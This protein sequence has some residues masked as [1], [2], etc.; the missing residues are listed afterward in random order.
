MYYPFAMPGEP[1]TV[2]Q[3]D[4]EP[5]VRLHRTFSDEEFKSKLEMTKAFCETAKGYVQI[6]AA[7]LA[8]PLL[9]NEAILG[10][11]KSES[12]LGHV[13]WS[14]IALWGLLVVSISC[15]LLYQWLSMRKLW[16]Q[17]HGGHRTI[18]NMREA[19]YR[20]TKVIPQT[21]GI[22]LSY[23]WFGMMFGLML[24]AIFFVVYAWGIIAHGL[25]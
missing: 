4:S 23:V 20:I 8:V 1:E 2:V 15:G 21:G 7:G 6:S 25:S 10:K 16:D 3:A 11:T 5:D 13:P 17:Y 24:G 18:H 14:L 19:G 12:G 22:N 9:L